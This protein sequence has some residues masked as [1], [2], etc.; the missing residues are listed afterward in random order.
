MIQNKNKVLY[1]KYFRANIAKDK[2]K[3]LSINANII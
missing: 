3:K 2:Q 1:K